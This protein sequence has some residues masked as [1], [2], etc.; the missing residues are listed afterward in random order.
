MGISPSTSPSLDDRRVYIGAR[1]GSVYAYDL[2]RI[3]ELYQDNLLPQWSHL[4]LVWRYKANKEI[5]SPPITTGVFVLFASR[6]GSLYSVSA[7]R[8]QLKFQFETDFPIST[9]MAYANGF[10]FMASEDF[11]LYKINANNGQVLWSYG[12][13]LPI[14]KPPRVIENEIFIAPT[15][16]GLHC[17]NNLND[18]KNEQIGGQLK[19]KR[20]KASEFLAATPTTVYASDRVGNIL[21]LSREDGATTGVLPLRDFSIRISNARTDRLIIAT[22]RGLVAC[23]REK[24]QEFP[25]Y[26]EHPER[27]P[28]LPEFTIDPKPPLPGKKP[29]MP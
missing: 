10:V 12:A 20:A 6:G 14:R 22:T 2:R 17:V 5:A 27:R 16:G 13:G 7:E 18:L 23:I 3:K 8:R 29:A 11:K 9:P 4:T 15:R 21:L 24:G 1:D 28:L 25:L 19:W 26:H